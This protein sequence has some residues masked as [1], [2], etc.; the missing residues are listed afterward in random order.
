MLIPENGLL[1]GAPDPQTGV[2]GSDE[3]KTI[4]FTGGPLLV[5]F[6]LVSSLVNLIFGSASAKL[7]LLVTVFV[8]MRMLMGYSPETTQAAYWIGDSYSNILTPLLPYFPLLIVFA[9]KYVKNVGI[10]TLISL[11]L[12]YAIAFA[13]V[14]IPMLLLWIWAVLP[15]GIEGPIFY[16]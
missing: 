9:Q 3:L 10:G 11:M 7:A 8:P 14:R 4:S 1:R 6:I 5:A 16:Q 13:V 2:R 12:S 15:L